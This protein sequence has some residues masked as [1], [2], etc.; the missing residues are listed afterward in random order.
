[1]NCPNCKRDKLLPARTRE[2]TP[3]VDGKK[4]ANCGSVYRGNDT[5]NLVPLSIGKVPGTPAAPEA[6][7]APE[8]NSVRNVVKSLINSKTVSPLP[9]APHKPRG[10][11]Q[12][13]SEED[14]AEIVRRLKAGETPPEIVKAVGCTNTTVYKVRRKLREEQAGNPPKPIAVKP[15][16]GSRP[17]TLSM[18][19]NTM[20]QIYRLKRGEIPSKNAYPVL[21]RYRGMLCYQR[22]EALKEARTKKSQI[23]SVDEIMAELKA[24]EE[25]GKKTVEKIAALVG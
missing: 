17:W 24:V 9:E 16:N 1:M 21:E 18:I 12:H 3:A 7:A 10:Q 15:N 22:D 20:S 8:A 19:G 25:E 11:G 5:N 6:I 2:D 23:E 14:R 13:I 4:C